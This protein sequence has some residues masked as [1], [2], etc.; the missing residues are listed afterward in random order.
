MRILVVDDEKEIRD[1]IKS[2]LV[3]E[4]FT[5]DVTGEGER[6]SFLARTNEYDLIVLDYVLPVMSG[7]EVCHDIR[8]GGKTMPIIMLS[9]ES[10]TKAKIKLLSS[11]ADDYVTKPFALEEL[12]A[13]IRALLRRPK[14]ITPDV[15]RIQDLFVDMPRHTVRRAG[16]TIYLTRKEFELLEYLMRNRGVVLTRAMI[17]E[18][19]WDVQADVFSNTIETHI[20]NLRRKIDR[21]AKSKLIHTVPG[22]GYKIDDTD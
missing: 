17:M 4:G 2:S 10:D 18:H 11:G 21:D 9:V 16:Q 20:L 1:F 22:R 19:V 7:L 15:L 6:A 5:V 14:P 8:K 3:A 13:R 12:L